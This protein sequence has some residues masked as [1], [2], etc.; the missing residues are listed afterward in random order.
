MQ[1]RRDRRGRDSRD[2]GVVMRLRWKL[3][4]ALAGL[5]MLIAA[6][7][8]PAADAVVLGPL[9]SVSANRWPLFIGLDKG[10]FAAENIKPDLVYIPASAAVIQQ[11]AAGSLDMTISTGLVDPIRAIDQGAALGILRFDVQAPPYALIGKPT[12]KTLKELKRKIIPLP[13]P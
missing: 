6:A 3:E 7:P 9:G 13:R 2:G 12:V 8:V 5:F 10:F 1:R 4:C 11:L